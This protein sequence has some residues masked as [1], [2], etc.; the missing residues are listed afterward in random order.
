MA[1]YITVVWIKAAVGHLLKK[2]LSYLLN[3]SQTRPHRRFI[4]PNN[5][6]KKNL[7]IVSKNQSR[8]RWPLTPK[9]GPW[10]L[11]HIMLLL[12]LSWL[13]RTQKEED[14]VGGRYDEHDWQKISN[15]DVGHCTLYASVLSPWH[16]LPL[17]YRP[18]DWCRFFSSALIFCPECSKYARL[19]TLSNGHFN[20]CRFQDPCTHVAIQNMNW[21]A[22]YLTD[23]AIS[24]K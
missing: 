2:S 14:L 22:L 4:T 12:S 6:E 17:H 19:A 15:I 1:I 20:K 7:G 23:S 8:G 9:V 3:F 24:L 10:E 5:N 21:P 13:V 11:L 18:N 16:V